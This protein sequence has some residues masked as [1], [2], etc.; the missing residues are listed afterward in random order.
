MPRPRIWRGAQSTQY[1][2]ARGRFVDAQTGG[3]VT[4]GSPTDLVVQKLRTLIR[5]KASQESPGS[6]EQYRLQEMLELSDD[7]LLDTIYSSADPNPDR[8]GCPPRETLRELAMRTR[9]LSDPLWDHVMEC[10]PC[11]V[12]VREMGRGRAVTPM[13]SPTR[14]FGMVAAAVFVLGI[15]LGAWMLTRGPGAPTPV[16]GDLR[17][18]TVMRSDQPQVSGS[19]LV[20]PRRLVRLT[21][22]MPTGS[23]PGRYELEVRGSDGLA[24]A[25]A[26]GDAT[27][28]DLI[29]RLASEIDLRSTPRGPC[30]LAT[31]RTGEGWQTFPIRIQ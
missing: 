21:L 31:R 6:P 19:A 20:L 24:R 1:S 22:L 12:D 9:P 28:Q 30:L 23:E 2:D 17:P 16:I 27:L 15:G 13:P 7:A 18:Y 4:Q 14:P 26:S 29:T 25:T 5:D 11:R 3:R 10:A 8:I